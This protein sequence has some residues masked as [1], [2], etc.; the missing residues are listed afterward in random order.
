MTSAMATSASDDRPVIEI[1]PSTGWRAID[2]T[3]LFRYREL[4]VVLVWR[5]LKVRYRQT[6]LGVAWVVA[7]PILTMVIFTVLF[8]RVAKIEPDRDVPYSLFVMAGLVPWAFFSSAV[9][10]ASNS[11]IGSAHLISKV[12]FPRM[13]VPAAAVLAAVADLFV[14]LGIVA[15]MAL[16]YS[17]TPGPGLLLLPFVVLLAALFALGCGFWLS[18]LNVEYR[19]VRVIVP[20][21]LQI[22]MYATP[23]VYPRTV[24]P[25]RYR[26]VIDLNPMTGIIEGFRSS[27]I[28]GEIPWLSLGV[29]LLVTLLLVISGAYFFRRVERMF[30]DHL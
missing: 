3:E 12:Y 5:D 1:V 9:S 16:V 28:H 4:L 17:V 29:S 30:A 27:L 13:L 11:L 14:T 2:V 24:V 22:W 26:W 10:A 23:V 7:Q 18:A 15:V 21:L 6:I 19:D 20:F 25:E 8:N